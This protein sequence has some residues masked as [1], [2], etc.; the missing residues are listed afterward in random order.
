MIEADMPDRTTPNLPSRDFQQT[1]VFYARLGFEERFRDNGWMI[2]AR[3][4]LELEFFPCPN[5]DPLTTIASCCIRVEDVDELHQAFSRA[6]LPE[7]GTPRLTP[8]KNEPWGLRTFA[9]VDPDGSLL[10]C[11]GPVK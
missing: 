5:I 1:A 8:P 3:G 7:K 6:G 9:L 11:L 2:L 4:P 10:R